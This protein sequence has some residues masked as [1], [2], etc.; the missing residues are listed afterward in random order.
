MDIADAADIEIQRG[1]DRTLANRVNLFAHKNTVC[2]CGEPIEPARID[3]GLGFCFS[4]AQ[5]RETKQAQ[6]YR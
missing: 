1:L 5:A 4:C 2:S 6:Y 3:L